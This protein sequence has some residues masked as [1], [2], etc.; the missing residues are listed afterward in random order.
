[1]TWNNLKILK[2]SIMKSGVTATAK[3]EQYIYIK[4]YNTDKGVNFINC[5]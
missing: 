3:Y 5:S 2:A 1:M 4:K